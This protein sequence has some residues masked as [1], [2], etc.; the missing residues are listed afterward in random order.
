MGSIKG[1]SYNIRVDFTETG[2]PVIGAVWGFYNASENIV[3]FKRV[4]EGIVLQIAKKLGIQK[5][6]R[7]L[8]ITRQAAKAK[9]AEEKQNI[10]TFENQEVTEPKKKA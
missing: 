7:S 5:S 3:D 4:P 6:S 9:K 10:F 1:R 2:E 8:R